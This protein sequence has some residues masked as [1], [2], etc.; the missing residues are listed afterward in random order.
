MKHWKKNTETEATKVKW[1][2]GEKGP[3]EP[4]QGRSALL[5]ISFCIA[6]TL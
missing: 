3:G 2:N 4:G 5:S 1:E 6:L